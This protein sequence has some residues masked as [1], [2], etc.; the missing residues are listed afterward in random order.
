MSVRTYTAADG[1]VHHWHRP[2][3]LPELCGKT[4]DTGPSS[5]WICLETWPCKYHADPLRPE[6][7]IR[8]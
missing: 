7:P 5:V 3:P 1:V 8:H 6:S 4:T 2:D